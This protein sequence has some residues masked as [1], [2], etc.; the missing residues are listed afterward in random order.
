MGWCVEEMLL[1]SFAFNQTCILPRKVSPSP[2]AKLRE[3]VSL[4]SA[5]DRSI[6]VWRMV[7]VTS[8]LHVPMATKP[9]AIAAIPMTW[10]TVWLFY[11]R[12]R[13]AMNVK[14]NILTSK[15]DFGS[16]RTG[17]IRDNTSCLLEPAY[18]RPS[19]GKKK[20]NDTIFSVSDTDKNESDFTQQES[21]LWP[22]IY[23]SRCSTTELQRTRWS[24]NNL[25]HLSPGQSEKKCFFLLPDQL[26]TR[27]AFATASPIIRS[28]TLESKVHVEVLIQVVAGNQ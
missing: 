18:A 21:N 6:I 19:L 14:L 20:S 5:S 12:S 22:S 23:W 25:T 17:R 13:P 10:K 28:G 11:K 8:P 3:F 16:A 15:F 1:L 7:D 4:T 26:L 9:Q 24:K 27:L 2:N